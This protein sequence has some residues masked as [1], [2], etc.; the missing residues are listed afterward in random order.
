MGY[1]KEKTAYEISEC[2]WSS[3]V[4]S[5][6]LIYGS[7]KKEDQFYDYLRKTKIVLIGKGET[8]G[9][10][11]SEALKKLHVKFNVIDSQTSEPGR[12]LKSAD[13]IISAVGK[14]GVIKSETLKKGVVLV[15]IGLSKGEDGKMHGDYDEEEIKDIASYYTPTPGGVGPVNVAC[16]L[17]N[18]V[19]ATEKI[20]F[21]EALF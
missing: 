20:S 3:D 16:L 19:E 5:S 9:H 10:P 13:I 15:S 8:G 17:Q 2:D 6:D 1:I 12:V 11:I 18:L 14:P 4:C 7:N 21:G